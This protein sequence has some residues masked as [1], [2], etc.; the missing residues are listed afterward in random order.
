[1]SRGAPVAPGRASPRA[2]RVAPAA[3]AGSID[4]LPAALLPALGERGL[5][6]G[7]PHLAAGRLR[8][9]L[10]ASTLVAAPALA[11]VGVSLVQS[12]PGTGASRYPV[13][14][15]VGYDSLIGAG[16]PRGRFPAPATHGRRPGAFYS[17]SATDTPHPPP[18]PPSDHTAAAAAATATTTTTAASSD[19]PTATP[20]TEPEED[21]TRAASRPSRSPRRSVRVL[22]FRQDDPNPEL[23]PFEA[24]DIHPQFAALQAEF[25]GHP[26][27]A[28]TAA[29]LAE[30]AN[31]PAPA[32]GPAG[33]RMVSPTT[34]PRQARRDEHLLTGVLGRIAAT[35]PLLQSL[36]PSRPGPGPG[37]GP[38]SVPVFMPAPPAN[39]TGPD[40]LGAEALAKLTAN[41]T[42]STLSQLVSLLQPAAAGSSTPGPHD[43]RQTLLYLDALMGLLATNVTGAEYL[44]RSRAQLCVF[45]GAPPH[46]ATICPVVD[47]WCLRGYRAQTGHD[48][49]APV[50]R[51]PRCPDCHGHPHGL[52]CPLKLAR[53]LDLAGGSYVPS[54]G[55]AL[56][57]PDLG[58]VKADLQDARQREAIGTAAALTPS[59]H[60]PSVEV[61]LAVAA[62]ALTN[63]MVAAIGQRSEERRGGSYVPS[64]GPALGWPDLG[65][66]KADLQDARQREAIG[67]A[68]ALTP[69]GHLPSVEVSLAVA[70]KALT[71]L[72]VAAIGQTTPPAR[73]LPPGHAAAWS[74]ILSEIASNADGNPPH[75]AH[76]DHAQCN[77]PEAGDDGQHRHAHQHPPSGDSPLPA[78]A[79]PD[80]L[81]SVEALVNLFRQTVDE[82]LPKLPR[83]STS[84]LAAV[85]LFSSVASLLQERSTV[86]PDQSSATLRHE[87]TLREIMVPCG[88]CG[89]HEAD[90]LCMVLL[91]LGYHYAGGRYHLSEATKTMRLRSGLCAACGQHPATEPCPQPWVQRMS[92]GRRGELLPLGKALAHPVSDDWTEEQADLCRYCGEH[93]LTQACPLLL[94]TGKLTFNSLGR[95]QV[96]Q[97][98]YERRREHRLC[99]FCGLHPASEPC[100]G[101]IR[102]GGF[103]F[104]LGHH[105]VSLALA[106]ERR[107]LRLCPYCGLH[108]ISSDPCPYLAHRGILWDPVERKHVPSHDERSRRESLGLCLYCGMHPATQVCVALARKQRID[109]M[110]STILSPNLS[111]IVRQSLEAQTAASKRMAQDAYLR[112]AA[113]MAAQALSRS[114]GIRMR[115]SLSSGSSFSRA[116]S[117][118]E[119]PANANAPKSPF[120]IPN[121]SQDPSA[122]PTSG[123]SSV[124]PP[125]QPKTS[126]H[127]LQ[128]NT[129]FTA[130]A[131]QVDQPDASAPQEGSASDV[132][133]SMHSTLPNFSDSAR[134]PEGEEQQQQ[135]QQQHPDASPPQAAS[136]PQETPAETGAASGDGPAKTP[137]GPPSS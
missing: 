92:L 70:A 99:R 114:E 102:K 5:S 127:W 72:M 25:M 71:N 1:M 98:E 21:R 52:A 67:T 113:D 59:G 24:P 122:R 104:L 41:P 130:H 57:W 73:P 108:E 76:H 121:F 93:P 27:T 3:M 90:E 80:V 63:L 16:P 22:P 132:A 49:S 133:A 39:P 78:V 106:N 107:R 42:S 48:V 111:R 38:A 11:A 8:V 51:F 94:A 66:V 124:S 105:R 13:R 35:N 117:P 82:Q 75:A 17:T 95:Y 40:P 136:F 31:A 18:L 10:A 56:G 79:E 64:T 134:E 30:A 96:T 50:D 87:V 126:R 62:K 23:L 61:S 9:V 123:A 137:P 120:L 55:P 77:H 89:L 33:V 84:I 47:W 37:P 34:M 135:Q 125:S 128:Q 26:R 101:I 19:P 69:S 86:L 110:D 68:A 28:P 129:R 118:T 32:P 45:C 58:S 116:D 88:V 60:L 119:A 54:T 81:Q 6:L 12:G 65:S 83:Q 103:D 4:R 46:G 53:G 97:E 15:P 100:S 85:N 14:R 36:K 112:A 109:E 29:V 74:P 131:A 2:P 91:R 43:A 44:R 7:P 20:S 115:S